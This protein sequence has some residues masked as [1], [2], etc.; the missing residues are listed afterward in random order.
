[1]PS[2]SPT[3]RS[4]FSLTLTSLGMVLAASTVGLLLFLIPWGL[5]AD[6]I[7]ERWVMTMGLLLGAT[8]LLGAAVS[9][10]VASLM[11]SMVLAGAACASVN[12][13]SGRAVILWFPRNERG[14]AMGARQTAIPLGAA[15]ASLALPAAAHAWGLRGAFI[16]A[17][18]G[19]TAGALVVWAFIRDPD[20]LGSE[21][22]P[23][24]TPESGT[25]GRRAVIQLCVVSFLLILPQLT[26]VGFLVVYL[27]DGHAMSAAAAA[28]LLAVVQLGG[29]AARLGL[30]AWSDRR[31]S[32]IG[33]LQYVATVTSALFV[34]A[35]VGELVGGAVAVI[36]LVLAGFASISWN[37]LAFTAIGELA[38]PNRIGLL[39]GIQNTAVA[40]GM[41][42][43][44]PLMG[45]VV[46]AT[47]WSFAFGVVATVA[48]LAALILSRLT[49]AGNGS[50][51]TNTKHVRKSRFRTPVTD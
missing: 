41:T 23:A 37:G 43:T 46:D 34:I 15:V 29:G 5:L 26:I 30:G 19:C 33:P 18:A 48:A 9:T 7:G 24:Q 28:G 44:P 3:L 17:A 2:L 49:A 38:P 50:R 20:L 21:E 22:N 8:A 31:G 14:F 10:S 11:I 12:A 39:L 36:A 6:R 16:T 25:N 27:V 47:S 42:V 32:R 51:V 4:Q 13:A 1:M 40:A 35:V 45:I